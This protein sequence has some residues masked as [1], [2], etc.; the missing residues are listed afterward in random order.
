MP[1]QVLPSDVFFQAENAKKPFIYDTPQAIPLQGAAEP[2]EKQFSGYGSDREVSL[3]T[4]VQLSTLY[5]DRE[6]HN[7]LR[8]RQTDRQTVMIIADYTAC[9]STI[10]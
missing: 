3:F 4:V 8:H 6:C 9:S 1:E 10:G 5:T 2:P 7:T